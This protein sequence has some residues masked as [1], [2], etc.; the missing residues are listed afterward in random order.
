[1]NNFD[2]TVSL[3]YNCYP[4]LFENGKR[5]CFFDDIATPA[6]AIKQLLINNFNGFYTRSN[7]DR[8]QIFD[9]SKFECL[10]NTKYYLRFTNSYQ[11][12]KLDSLF[13]TFKNKQARFMNKLTSDKKILFIRYEEPI[14]SDTPRFSGNRIIYS[15]YTTYYQQNELYYMN[16]LSTYLKTTYPNLNFHIM[17]IGNSLNPP[18]QL[19]YDNNSK[20][21]TI[22]NMSIDTANYKEVIGQIFIDHGDFINSSLT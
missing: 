5:D 4:N 8:I 20:I 16:D 1:M 12:N 10:T 7:Y 11:I 17:F 14:V 3:G 21:F 2:C 22:P 9:A 6:W 13:T 19:G 18:V 15:D